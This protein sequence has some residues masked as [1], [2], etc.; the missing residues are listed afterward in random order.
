M[1]NKTVNERMTDSRAER[2]ALAEEVEERNKNPLTVTRPGGY[3]HSSTGFPI[4][5]EGKVL[6]E[7][8]WK[9]EDLERIQGAGAEVPAAGELAAT[10]K[11][12]ADRVEGSGSE[13]KGTK[14]RPR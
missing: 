10:K 4:D 11:E 3:F 5:C 9:P 8:E 7:S 6:P 12:G 14:T 13:Q 1:A 2:L